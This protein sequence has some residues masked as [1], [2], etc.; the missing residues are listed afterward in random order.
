MLFSYICK[1]CHGDSKYITS[2][3]CRYDSKDKYDI[4][5]RFERVWFFEKIFQ[6]CRLQ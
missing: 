1:K 3:I 6:L 5:H 2:E 4:Y